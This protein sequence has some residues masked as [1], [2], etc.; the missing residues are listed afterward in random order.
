M[1]NPFEVLIAEESGYQIG[2]ADI[3]AYEDNERVLLV[4][5]DIGGVDSKKIQELIETSERL[6]S[7]NGYREL[8]FVPVLFTPKDVRA[9]LKI[10][11]VAVADGNVIESMLKELAK[12]DRKSARSQIVRYYAM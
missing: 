7:L 6:G 9:D 3:I 1:K 5:C 8:N 10:N 2:T 4:D 11:K 12:G